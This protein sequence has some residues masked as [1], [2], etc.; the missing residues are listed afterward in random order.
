M[1]EFYKAELKDRFMKYTM[2]RDDYVQPEE[3]YQEFL[4][5][6]YQPEYAIQILDEILEFD[7]E[8]F[9]V[10][11]GNGSRI[12]MLSATPQTFEFIENGG[13]KNLYIQEEEKWEVF[14]RHLSIDLHTG[15]G[16]DTRAERGK[17]LG[18]ERNNR[19]DRKVFVGLLGVISFSFLYSL[20][21]TIG[22]L[23]TPQTI[24]QKEFELRLEEL[25]RQHR[26]EMQVLREQI[27]GK[28][29]TQVPPSA[30]IPVDSLSGARK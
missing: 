26:I 23:T 16:R 7:S 17:Q 11:S 30:P 3:L 10:I 13:F 28:K 1:T 2:D 24:S 5:P 12:F 8:L 29:Y 22:S 20:V 19:R 14:L 9:D 15:R 4:S 25:Q 21:G 18:I 27:E 6:N